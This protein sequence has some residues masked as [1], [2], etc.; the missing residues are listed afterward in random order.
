MP[1]SSVAIC[2]MAL[3]MVGGQRIQSIEFPTSV[4]GTMCGILYEPTVDEV[5][6][7]HEWAC[8]I[9]RQELA[10][11]A[12]PPITSDFQYAYQLPQ[13]PYCLRALN[14]PDAPD[15]VYMVEGRTLLC[16]LSQVKLRYIKR[17]S[18]PTQF[19][20][21]LVKAIAL[22]LAADLAIAVSDSQISRSQ[23]MQLYELQLRRAI[24]VN[25]LE[26]EGPG[27]GDEAFT[28]RDAGRR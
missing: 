25:A 9:H 19:D 4:E 6:R 13:D 1:I 16:N 20:S 17:V 26:R 15:A 23:A 8:A 22:R 18:D 14:I 28:V 3:A 10:P 7:S 11:L 21:L 24:A 12:D 2:N 5:L 27:P